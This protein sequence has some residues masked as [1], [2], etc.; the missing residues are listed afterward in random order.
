MNK[1]RTL[2]V[3]IGIIAIIVIGLI[4]FNLFLELWVKLLIGV[5]FLGVLVIAV[6][7]LFHGR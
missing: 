4:N 6:R 5:V 2:I 7:T 3:S 1:I